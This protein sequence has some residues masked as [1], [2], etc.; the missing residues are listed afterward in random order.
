MQ[1]VVAVVGGAFGT[2]AA[3]RFSRVSP[4][5]ARGDRKS[6]AWTWPAHECGATWGFTEDFTD[7][8]TKL[9][10]SFSNVRMLCVCFVR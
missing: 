1:V 7:A 8:A 5:S 9:W 6:E 4:L 3:H 10:F 2:G